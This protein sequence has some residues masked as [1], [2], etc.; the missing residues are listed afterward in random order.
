MYP[1]AS[2]WRW[3]LGQEPRA[4]GGRLRYV[5]RYLRRVGIFLFV[6]MASAGV[7]WSIVGGSSTVAFS[8]V[9]AGKPGAGPSQVVA[10]VVVPARCDASSASCG[11]GATLITATYV[12]EA[13]VYG[14]SIYKLMV[15][16]K[17]RFVPVPSA[18]FS[19]ASASNM[20]L[21]AFGYPAR[22]PSGEP[23]A[24]W[25]HT[26]GR[27][28]GSDGPAYGYATRS[29][30]A[31]GLC[32]ASQWLRSPTFPTPTS[33]GTAPGFPANCQE[34]PSGTADATSIS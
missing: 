31:R 29:S 27:V 23:L 22:P 24:Q 33:C 16:G 8:G 30:V 6:V 15:I 18:S 32:I 21:L 26:Y 28:I 11:Q 34:V 4:T 10:P 2:E 14:A 13:T 1:D 20:D 9:S 25:E 7:G 3:S 17:V 12:G 5:T 19:P